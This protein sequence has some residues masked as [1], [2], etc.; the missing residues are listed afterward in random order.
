MCVGVLEEYIGHEDKTMRQAVMAP[1][2]SDNCS[3]ATHTGVIGLARMEPEV[4]M[5]GYHK[6]P[7]LT[8]A[9]QTSF[10]IKV[11]H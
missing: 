5:I 1:H 3:S 11:N 8:V 4:F 10:S 6:S 2:Q 7:E 9:L